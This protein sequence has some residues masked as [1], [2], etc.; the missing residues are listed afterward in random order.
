VAVRAQ[1]DVNG[2]HA[3]LVPNSA[4]A[5]QALGGHLAGLNAYLAEHH[6][7]VETLTM[8]APES[9]AHEQSFNQRG[10]QGAGQ[11]AGQNAGQG[12]GQGSMSGHT[13]Q[14]SDSQRD[15]IPAATA[16]RPIVAAA[17][18]ERV[19]ESPTGGVYISV[20]A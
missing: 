11:D 6:S 9:R 19:V 8:A 18:E 12:T 2:V 3:S 13:G 1:A 5:A 10:G 14:P 4:D 15:R 16:A 20:M 7:A 17:A